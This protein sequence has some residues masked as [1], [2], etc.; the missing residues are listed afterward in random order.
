LGD[1]RYLLDVVLTKEKKLIWIKMDHTMITKPMKVKKA[2][3][4]VF[5]PTILFCEIRL[6]FFASLRKKR[7]QYV[8]VAKMM[9]KIRLKGVSAE[10]L[11]K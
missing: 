10:D 5:S 7:Y 1:I 6:A 4:D 8:M 2:L 9:G 3:A 11:A